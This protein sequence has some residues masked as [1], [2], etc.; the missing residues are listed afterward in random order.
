MNYYGLRM[1]WTT[2]NKRGS[3]EPDKL[4]DFIVRTQLIGIGDSGTPGYQTF[5]KDLHKGDIVVVFTLHTTPRAWVEVL[6]DAS[7]PYEKPVDFPLLNWM[8]RKR[9]I[10]V[11]SWYDDYQKKP[12]FPDNYLGQAVCFLIKPSSK[13]DAITKWIETVMNNKSVKDYAEMLRNAKNLIL[14]GAPGTG[15]TYLAKKIA[16]EITKDEDDL[17]QDKRH[18]AFVQFHPSYDYTDFVEGLRPTP[19]DKEN[20]NIGFQGEDGV[21]KAFCKRAINN[22]ASNFEEAYGRLC[23]D[24]EENYSQERPL[25]L[26]TKAQNKSFKVFLN[27]N[28]SLSLIT[29]GS[30]E[31]QGSL[32]PQRMQTFLTPSPYKYWKSYFS[33]VLEYMKQKYGLKTEPVNPNQ[34][35]VF[36]IDE[37]NRGDI[38]KIF[39]ELFYAIDPDYRGKKGTIKTQYANLFQDDEVFPNGMFYVPENVYIIGTMNDIDRNVECMDFAIRRRFTWVEIEPKDTIS[40]WNDPEKGI[41]EYKDKAQT[42]MN[43]INEAIKKTPGLGS[44]YQLGAAYFLKLKNYGGDF[45]KLWDNHIKPLLKEYLRGMPNADETL[46]GMEQIWKEN[47]P[48]N[49][50]ESVAISADA[51]TET[52][53]PAESTETAPSSADTE[54]Q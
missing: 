49:S 21:F 1:T 54:Q 47:T 22:Q 12:L 37:I 2:E 39:G 44:A 18:W 5:E 27:S 11:L 19:P 26:K 34:K 32:T 51:Q 23:D 16:K 40:M 42:C 9:R 48:S 50:T 53:Q 36:I 8:E 28:G 3:L 33:A 10:K 30:N 13:R 20:G 31:V 45:Q 52:E 35:Y 25:E 4:R 46:S 29:G 41:P 17:P 14:T 24:L 38:A 6:D 15:K 43:A 7:F